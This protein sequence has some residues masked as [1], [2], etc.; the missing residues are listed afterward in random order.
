MSF[1]LWLEEQ[2]KRSVSIW[3]NFVTVCCVWRAHNGSKAK[4]KQFTDLQWIT[5]IQITWHEHE[6]K[7][8]FIPRPCIIAKT[9]RFSCLLLLAF[10]AMG[11]VFKACYRA[12]FCL[13]GKT[14]SVHNCQR[15]ALNSMISLTNCSDDTTA[16]L[17]ED[18]KNQK[19]WKLTNKIFV[20]LLWQVI[21]R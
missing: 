9:N 20:Q 15:D 14:F 21:R 3:R 6:I 4:E 19:L 5:I 13:L 2:A 1:W 17:A 18:N 16:K 11:M 12:S 7:F 10:F 8:L